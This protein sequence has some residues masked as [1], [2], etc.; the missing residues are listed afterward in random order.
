M[1]VWAQLKATVQRRCSEVPFEGML[2]TK[3]SGFTVRFTRFV[4]CFRKIF[5]SLCPVVPVIFSIAVS[6]FFLL[7][8]A[9]IRTKTLQVNF[10]EYTYIFLY[11]RHCMFKIISVKNHDRLS[12]SYKPLLWTVYIADRL[13]HKDYCFHSNCKENKI[14]LNTFEIEVFTF[15]CTNRPVCYLVGS[16]SVSLPRYFLT[17]THSE[18]QKGMTPAMLVL[19][20]LF[21]FVLFWKLKTPFPKKK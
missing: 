20:F 7:H 3:K 4:S 2:E 8:Q 16:C 12:I 11:V 17:Q 5:V 1:R 9:C 14:L 15:E 19:C 18:L 13:L 6:I 10:L 21:L